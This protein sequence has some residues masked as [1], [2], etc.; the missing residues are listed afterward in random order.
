MPEGEDETE[1]GEAGCGGSFLDLVLQGETTAC[2]GKSVFKGN[3]VASAGLGCA[4]VA[5]GG[6]AFLSLINFYFVTSLAEVCVCL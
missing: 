6:G 2:C 3:C 5:R 1:G 4:E